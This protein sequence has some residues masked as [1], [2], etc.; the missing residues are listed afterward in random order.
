VRIS[1]EDLNSNVVGASCVMSTNAIGDTPEISPRNQA[2]DEAIT[3][4]I[5]KIFF[6]KTQ[7]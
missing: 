4:A 7:A 1:S 2:I 3:A 6:M 5:L